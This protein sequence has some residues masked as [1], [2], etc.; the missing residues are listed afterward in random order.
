MGTLLICNRTEMRLI[1]KTNSTRA[2]Y[3]MIRSR[4]SGFHRILGFM[5]IKPGRYDDENGMGCNV[6]DLVEDR[7]N[8]IDLMTATLL[9]RDCQGMIVTGILC[10]GQL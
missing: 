6:D 1:S 8:I 7:K 2:S 4:Y 5:K 3:G 10:Q 9:S